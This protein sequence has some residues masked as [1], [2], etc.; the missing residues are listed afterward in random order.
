MPPSHAKRAAV[1]DRRARLIQMRL[2]GHSYDEITHVLGY[3]SRYDAS[4]DF[5]RALEANLAAEHTSFEVYRETEL[6]RLDAMYLALQQRIERGEPRAIEVALQ[7]SARRCKMLGLDAAQRL[8]VLT[9]DAIDAQIAA[10][11]E[12]LAAADREAREAGG[13]EAPSE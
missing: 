11:H 5:N 2:D 10:L 13:T 12:Q 4:R 3:S 9:I 1:A 7:V 6:R 8:E